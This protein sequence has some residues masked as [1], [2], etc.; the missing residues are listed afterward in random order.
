MPPVV[1]LGNRSKAVPTII[2]PKKLSTKI[3]AGFTEG[4]KIFIFLFES[5]AIKTTADAIYAAVVLFK[6]II[7][8]ELKGVAHIDEILTTEIAKSKTTSPSC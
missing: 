2:N 4:L 7:A 1:A 5:S 6:I 3:V 8:G